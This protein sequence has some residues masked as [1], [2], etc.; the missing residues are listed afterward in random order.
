[1]WLWSSFRKGRFSNIWGRLR[2]K[3]SI[4]APWLIHLLLSLL[5]VLGVMTL[6]RLCTGDLTVYSE[7]YLNGSCL[8]ILLPGSADA[9]IISLLWYHVTFCLVMFLLFAVDTGLYFYL[10]RNLQ[11]PVEDWR[12]SLSVKKR[13]APE[14]K[15]HL[16]AWQ[17]SC[18]ST[19][20]SAP[21]P[22]PAFLWKQLR[23]RPDVWSC[24]YSYLG[25]PVPGLPR[26]QSKCKSR[27]DNLVRY[28]FKK[29]RLGGKCIG[30]CLDGSPGKGTCG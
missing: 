28:Y 12:K 8:L 15:W 5:Y 30:V 9:T 16:I 20:F 1:M 26:L 23:T 2:D 18:G 27:L 6:Q 10:Q 22:P 24:N 3:K 17:G 11:T 7:Y 29:S 21:H 19:I 13:Q 14:G 25:S 4:K